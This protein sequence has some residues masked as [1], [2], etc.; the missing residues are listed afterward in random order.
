MK[1]CSLRI[2]DV[3]LISFEELVT[4]DLSYYDCKKEPR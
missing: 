3:I 1:Q 4:A 2:L